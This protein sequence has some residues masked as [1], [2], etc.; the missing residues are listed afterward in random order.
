MDDEV[1]V[2]SAILIQSFHTKLCKKEGCWKKWSLAF[3]KMIERRE[4]HPRRQ[5]WI[6]F[7]RDHLSP[8]LWSYHAEGVEDR[9]LFIKMRREAGLPPYSNS[10][11]YFLTQTRVTNLGS[12]SQLPWTARMNV[13]FFSLG[14]E[15][16]RPSM[17][18]NSVMNWSPNFPRFKVSVSISLGCKVHLCYCRL[19]FASCCKH[20]ISL[21]VLG[22]WGWCSMGLI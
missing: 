14:L 20:P 9:G 12:D 18:C 22:K 3:Q 7:L 4:H 2:Y 15:S 6:Q 19:A 8:L 17:F 21:K 1:K 16:N 10:F 13:G 5:D 11:G